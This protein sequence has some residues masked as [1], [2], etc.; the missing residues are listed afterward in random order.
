MPLC[1]LVECLR[2]TRGSGDGD[3]SSAS[4]PMSAWMLAVLYLLLVGFSRVYAGAHFC[5]DVIGAGILTMVGSLSFIALLF[6]YCFLDRCQTGYCRSILHSLFAHMS[7]EIL[8]DVFSDEISSSY[9]LIYKYI[10]MSCPAISS[11]NMVRS[12]AAATRWRNY[13]KCVH[14]AVHDVLS[15]D[16]TMVSKFWNRSH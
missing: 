1:C 5:M 2:R 9:T 15:S 8:P 10:G 12:T 3:V 11:R 14:S 7:F 6:A 13:R 4:P 16:A